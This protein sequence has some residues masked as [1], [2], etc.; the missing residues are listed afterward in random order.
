MM[1]AATRSEWA[2]WKDR[3]IRWATQHFG[4]DLSDAVESDPGHYT[5]F[6]AF[7]TRALKR[8]SRPIDPDPAAVVSPVDGEVSQ[9]GVI[10][11]GRLVQAKGRDFRLD[12]LLADGAQAHQFDG[13]SFITLYLAPRDYHRIHMPVAGTLT[14]MTHIPGRLFSVNHATTRA[15]PRLFARNERIVN[16]FDTPAG[17]LALVMVGAIFVGSMETRWAGTVTPVDRRLSRWDYAG[18]GNQPVSLDK[19]EEMG[20]F[21]MGSTVILVC[22]DRVQWQEVIPGSSL[23]VGERIGNIADR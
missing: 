14:H 2:P 13:G 5:S 19:G 8:E 17:P 10:H 1:Y 3:I 18:R 4:I 23:R 20:R 9:A 16:L 12:E 6:N 22:T 21:N 15:I 7:F 11:Q